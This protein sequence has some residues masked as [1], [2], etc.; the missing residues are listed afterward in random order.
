MNYYDGLLDTYIEI[1][2]NQNA[3]NLLDKLEKYYAEDMNLQ[4]YKL[5]MAAD[6]QKAYVK[7]AENAD[8]E[9]QKGT[10]RDRGRYQYIR[11]VL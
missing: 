5:S 7:L 11:F 10:W 4:K 1:G 3:L 8:S 9:I 6:W 2:D